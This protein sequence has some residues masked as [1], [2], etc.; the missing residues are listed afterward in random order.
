MGSWLGQYWRITALSLTSTFADTVYVG[1]VIYVYFATHSGLDD[2]RALKDFASDYY[3]VSGKS[4]SRCP[5][6]NMLP[7]MNKADNCRAK[8]IE[9]R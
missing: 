1:A 4:Y 8:V 6:R 2:V 9:S 7:R 5:D 3:R